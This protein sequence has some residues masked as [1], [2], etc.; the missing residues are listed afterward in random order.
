M[1]TRTA[2]ITVAPHR[3]E[4]LARR[5]RGA[6]VPPAV[7]STLS[8]GAA[9]AL[10]TI[11][12]L[13]PRAPLTQ[14]LLTG[15][16]VLLTVA[17]LW[18]VRQ[19]VARQR[20]A[21]DAPVHRLS[22]DSTPQRLTAGALVVPSGAGIA[23]RRSVSARWLVLF[24][25]ASA[26]AGA[27]WLAQL[28]LGQRAATLAMVVPGPA[29][30]LTAGAWSLL[31]V[32]LGLAVAAALRRL[33]RL[34][35]RRTPKPLA[36]TLLAGVTVTS[37]AAG[38]IDLLEPLRKDLGDN[39]VM[40]VDSPAGASRS[41]ALV[42]ESPTPQDGAEL[43]VERMVADGGLDKDAV[44]IALPTG[45][46]WVNS[47]AVTA[48]ETQLD[49]DVAVVS[50]Q[51]GDLPSWWSFLIDQEPAKESAQALVAGVLARVAELPADERPD[52]F[53]HGESLGALAGQ[54]AVAHVD[55]DAICGVVWS[56]APGGA[57]SGHPRERS[58]HNADDPVSYLSTDTVLAKPED[59]PTTWLPGLS[60]GTT[61]LD[62][63]ASLLPDAGHGHS[64][65]PEQDWTLPTC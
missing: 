56:G 54:E 22:T 28:G 15:A 64:Y 3:M 33:A 46:G 47:E 18:C 14:G 65:G 26:V 13:L 63:G 9:L 51:Y 52:V 61:V 36:A 45:S 38:P 41:F 6:L 11:P 16:L 37:A 59:W 12:S 39:H 57:E 24:G 55:Q 43:A 62:L 40:L 27:A 48:F 23:R 25:T 35:W 58:L 7:G 30:W 8:V 50:A 5:L 10:S 42:D 1:L 34:T 4:A 21:T 49:G 20:P 60:Y 19:V 29:Y 31:V 2:L 53:I 32:G 17:V 44:L